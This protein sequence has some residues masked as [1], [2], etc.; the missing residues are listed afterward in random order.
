LAR[1]VP[2]P[3]RVDR[4]PV[5]LVA[6]LLF[7]CVTLFLEAARQA[8]ARG[9]ARVAGVWKGACGRGIWAHPRAPISRSRR[10][11]LILVTSWLFGFLYVDRLESLLARLWRQVRGR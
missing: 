8:L 5:A 10:V 9:P 4:K 6:I 7:S 1:L 3:A 11:L 2:A